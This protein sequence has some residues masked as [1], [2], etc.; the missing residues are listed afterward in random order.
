MSDEVR[1]VT[2][3]G[4]ILRDGSGDALRDKDGNFTAVMEFRLGGEDGEIYDTTVVTAKTVEELDETE[5][6]FPCPG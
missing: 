1:H 4:G 2:V 3:T 6:D 5:I